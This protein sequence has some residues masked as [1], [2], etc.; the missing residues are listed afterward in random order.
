MLHYRESFAESKLLAEKVL[1]ETVRRGVCPNP[2]NFMVWYEYLL[3][4]DAFVVDRITVATDDEQTA[5]E[6]FNHI[7]SRICMMSE[8]DGL[9]LKLVNDIISDMNGWE[10]TLERHTLILEQ[11]LSDLSAKSDVNLASMVVKNVVESIKD[12]TDSAKGMRSK[13]EEVRSEVDNLKK[14]LEVSHKEA[15]TDPLTGIGNRRAMDKFVEDNLDE[16]SSDSFS[17]II[18]DIDFFKRINDQHGHMVGDS[19]LRFIAKLLQQAIKG[20]DFVGRF[21]GE[22][23]I[24]LLPQTSASN[25]YAFAEKLRKLLQDTNLKL[26]NSHDTLKFTAS[27]G[28]STYRKGEKVTDFINRADNALYV[29]KETG[30]NRVVDE[31]EASNTKYSQ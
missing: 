18:L 1:E 29:A 31:I 10:S 5:I 27:L 17:C 24:M 4:R 16:N 15:H 3:K 26:R 21:G 23:F 19:V 20:Q 6:L 7:V 11:A 28:V 13:M 9:V 22:E 14:Q 8:I 12:L 25:A 2:I 30:R